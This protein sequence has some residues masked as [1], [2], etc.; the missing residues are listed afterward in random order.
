MDLY[1]NIEN[2]SKKKKLN[3]N[4]LKYILPD[5]FNYT[6][7]SDTPP[8]QNGFIILSEQQYQKLLYNICHSKRFVSLTVLDKYIKSEELY[9]RY[10]LLYKLLKNK[11]KYETYD[12]NSNEA[13]E[14]LK[15]KICD[16]DW[17]FYHINFEYDKKSTQLLFKPAITFIEKLKY[18]KFKLLNNL[19][20]CH[21]FNMNTNTLCNN[22]L[23]HHI[24]E[25]TCCKNNDEIIE[26]ILKLVDDTQDVNM[27]I[28]WVNLICELK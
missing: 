11:N 2:P 1:E 12:W 6:D 4:K 16:Y 26:H 24:G 10:L 3:M 18:H 25:R 14:I 9:N 5:W 13:K 17:R 7:L 22:C 27:M 28:Y 21:S 8:T 19:N 15:I 20:I 23:I